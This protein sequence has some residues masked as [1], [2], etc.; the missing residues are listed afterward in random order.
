[1]LI[2][3]QH[4]ARRLSV[5]RKPLLIGCLLMPM[6]ILWLALAGSDGSHGDRALIP[7]ILFFAWLLL[8][9]TALALFAD[10]PERHS[11]MNWWQRQK[12]VMARAFYWLLALLVVGIA[13]ATLVTTWQLAS[14]WVYMYVL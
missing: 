9:N 4:I 11:D 1:M 12:V 7:A 5:L 14:V 8:L 13:A 2:R 10:V 6:V 3:L